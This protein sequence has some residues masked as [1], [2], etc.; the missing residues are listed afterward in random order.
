MNN[1]LALDGGRHHFFDSS[2]LSIALSSMAPVDNP[3]IA[4]V[5]TASR[6]FIVIAIP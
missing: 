2:S 6:P 4:L 3:E 5:Q 1:S